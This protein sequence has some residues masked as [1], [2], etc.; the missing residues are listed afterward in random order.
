MCRIYL[1]VAPF[2]SPILMTPWITSLICSFVIV[3]SPVILK[4]NATDFLSSGSLSHAYRS[5]ISILSIV[6]IAL[7]ALRSVSH[8]SDLLITKQISL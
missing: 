3:P 8:E 5:N 1:S 2:F 6:S 4:V 7:I